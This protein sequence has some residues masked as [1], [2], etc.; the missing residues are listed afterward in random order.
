MTMIANNTLYTGATP[1]TETDPK[2]LDH[3]EQ[4]SKTPGASS[5]GRSPL[6]TLQAALSKEG[7]LTVAW[8]YPLPLDKP[9]PQPEGS[10]QRAFNTINRF[11]DQGLIDLGQI[12]ALFHQVVQAQRNSAQEG[13]QAQLR[14]QVAQ[15]ENAAENIRDS[16][17]AAFVGAMVM[18]V[19]SIAGGILS[20]A[21]SFKAGLNAKQ[22]LNQSQEASNLK[23]TLDSPDTLGQRANIRSEIN[24]LNQQSSNLNQISQ[25]TLGK[26]QGW[27]SLSSGMGGIGKGVG[28][29]ISAQQQADSKKSEAMATQASGQRDE[30][31]D[32]QSRMQQMMADVR[33]LLQQI[34]QNQMETA[35]TILRV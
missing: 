30:S 9:T 31:I 3:F 5:M 6:L 34:S 4:G 21:G 15:L 25:S 7:A 8:Q 1:L 27:S 19:L 28:D 11:E 23:K 24:T 22:G 26:W 33:Q 14:V 18:G 16:A 13:R 29:Y 10:Y 12:L 17:V 35:R 32:Y 20:T 2:M